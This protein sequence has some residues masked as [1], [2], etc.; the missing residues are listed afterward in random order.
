VVDTILSAA[1]TAICDVLGRVERVSP[2]TGVPGEGVRP[3]AARTH[4]NHPTAD[5]VWE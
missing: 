3:G 2:S 5:F 1:A 4:N